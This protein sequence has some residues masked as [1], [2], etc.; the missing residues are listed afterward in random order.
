MSWRGSGTGN[1]QDPIP[2]GKLGIALD[3]EYDNLNDDEDEFDSDDTSQMSHENR[4]KIKWFKEFFERM[5][6]LN[7]IEEVDET[8]WHCPACQGGPGAIKWYRS[9][10]DL[11][12]HAKKIGTRKVKLHRELAELLEVELNK[13]TSINAP[14]AAQTLGYWKGLKEDARDP[15]I[16]W[17]PMV[18]IRNTMTSIYK[19]GKVIIIDADLYIYKQ[20]TMIRTRN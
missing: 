6:A 2:K 9:I 3:D 15:E 8:V 16:V 20:N 12:G 13:G 1:T 5:D 19:D 14:A 11:I 4:K 10:Q 17:P 18:V 7:N